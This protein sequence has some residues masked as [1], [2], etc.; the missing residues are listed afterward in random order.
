MS[1][2]EIWLPRAEGSVM[3]E[4]INGVFD[5]SL[6]EE[7][8]IVQFRAD[9][10]FSPEEGVLHED[11]AKIGELFTSNL[12]SETKVTKQ[13]ADHFM[14]AARVGNFLIGLGYSER[15][16]EMP[17]LT[18]TWLGQWKRRNKNA[19]PYI[20]SIEDILEDQLQEARAEHSDYLHTSR[21][22]S[23]HIAE[24]TAGDEKSIYDFDGHN[25]KLYIKV[26]EMAAAQI[27]IMYRDH[28]AAERACMELAAEA[29]LFVEGTAI[30][31]AFRSITDGLEWEGPDN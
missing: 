24:E 15:D 11:I 10:C 23:E 29:D 5:R 8:Q 27:Y 20:K 6:N 19:T 12:A 13:L 25:T 18:E 22:W 1:E 9:M 14:N 7:L 21:C 30:D 31:E 28:E 3:L 2:P 17:T 26:G 16:R 4:A